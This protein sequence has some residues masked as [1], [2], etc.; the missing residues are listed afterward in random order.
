[1]IRQGQAELRLSHQETAPAEAASPVWKEDQARATWAA[2]VIRIRRGEGQAALEF[3]EKFEPGARLLFS[4]RIGPV[5]ADRLARDAIAGAV[6]EVRRGWM[7]IPRDL[8]HFLR[9]ILQREEVKCGPAP[10][11]GANDQARI[12]R[13]AAKLE[14]ALRNLTPM[15]RDALKRHY[16]G[17]DSSPSEAWAL[18]AKTS[19]A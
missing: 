2:L 7:N 16:L 11:L 4:R 12:R 19:G 3:A 5:R 18:A 6:A 13:K 10:A 1:M 8:V 15:E 9:N 17:P 14:V